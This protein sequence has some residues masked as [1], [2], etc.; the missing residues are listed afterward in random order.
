MLFLVLFA[1]GIL[2]WIVYRRHSKARPLP[3][4]RGYPIIG[5]VFDVPQ[6]PS[7]LQGFADLAT[8]R[9]LYLNLP[10]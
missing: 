1:A 7:A 2:A 4:P 9:H 3:G 5:N 10:R 6:G 8:V